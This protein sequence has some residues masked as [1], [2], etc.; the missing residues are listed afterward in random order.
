MELS[1]APPHGW[2]SP[3]KRFLLI[4]GPGSVVTSSYPEPYEGTVVSDLNY[5][6]VLHCSAMANPSP[7]ITWSLNGNVCGTQDTY[8]I[9][10]LA[11]KDL[12]NY[13]CTAQNSVGLRTSNPVHVQLP[14]PPSEDTDTE[15]SE[16]DSIYALSG[17]PAI[18]L[19][20]AG[21]SGIVIFIGVIMSSVINRKA[22]MKGRNSKCGCF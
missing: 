12:G 6:V 20:I 10:R 18:V 17:A 14:E 5:S 2:G 1:R 7:L 3:W 11:K 13:T 19:T 22:L 15:P 4:D 8:V 9:R 16:P 21:T